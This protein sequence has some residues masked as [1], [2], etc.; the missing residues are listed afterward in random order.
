MFDVQVLGLAHVF[1]NNPITYGYCLLFDLIPAPEAVPM[2]FIV[3]VTWGSRMQ[4]L[5]R[6]AVIQCGFTF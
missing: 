6:R 5:G 4:A 3:L 1:N 2:R